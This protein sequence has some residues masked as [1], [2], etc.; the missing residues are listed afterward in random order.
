MIRKWN[1][2]IIIVFVFLLCLVFCYGQY[3]YHK[4]ASG[5]V[6]PEIADTSFSGVFGEVRLRLIKV[7]LRSILENEDEALKDKG[8]AI[9]LVGLENAAGLIY[10]KKG[11][12]DEAVASFKNALEHLEKSGQRNY[13]AYSVILGNRIMAEN[14]IL[15]GEQEK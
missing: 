3:T 6:E 13:P 7:V 10:F 12:W 11:Q 4:N 14:N 2:R 5:G 9:E 8:D 1:Y 15:A